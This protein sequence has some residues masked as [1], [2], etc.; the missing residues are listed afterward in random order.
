V[1]TLVDGHWLAVRDGDSRVRALFARHYSMGKH[2]RMPP[3]LIVGP[4]ER[5]VLLTEDC[6]AMFVWRIERFRRDRQEGIN[7]AVFRNEGPMLSSELI[8]E[9]CELAWQRWPGERLFTYV[10]DAKIRS[11]NPGYCFKKAGFKRC[12]RN[13]DGRLTI[14]EILPTWTKEL[15]A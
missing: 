7:C 12:G 9:A 6:R 1:S 10:A 14:L 13:A 8:R 15:T 4:G 11:S 5:M 3:S 2:G